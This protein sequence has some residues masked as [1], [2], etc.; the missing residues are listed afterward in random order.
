M[1][2]RKC[3]NIRL[4]ITLGKMSILKT[5]DM[6]IYPYLSFHIDI[7]TFSNLHSGIHY[8]IHIRIPLSDGAILFYPPQGKTVAQFSW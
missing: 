6:R 8:N 2:I 4:L 7:F 1:W 3:L 5:K